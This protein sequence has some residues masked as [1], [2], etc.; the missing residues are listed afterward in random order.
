MGNVI[1][2]ERCFRLA[3]FAKIK[4]IPKDGAVDLEAGEGGRLWLLFSDFENDEKNKAQ[5]WCK[6]IHV[7][8]RT[9]KLVSGNS[10]RF[11]SFLYVLFS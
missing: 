3:L 4:P 6:S 7:G 11:P 8:L 2:S 5:T 10:F 9:L 1:R